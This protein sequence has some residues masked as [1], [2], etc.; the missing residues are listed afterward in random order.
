MIITFV[1]KLSSLFDTQV[2]VISQRWKRTFLA[3][4]VK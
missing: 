3:L 2:G 1:F 4:I